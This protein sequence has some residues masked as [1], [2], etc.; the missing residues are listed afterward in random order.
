MHSTV[1][2]PRTI[3]AGVAVDTEALDG[4]RR[5]LA[6]LRKWKYCNEDDAALVVDLLASQ[7]VAASVVNMNRQTQA[8]LKF[9]QDAEVLHEAIV[10][11]SRKPAGWAKPANLLKFLLLSLAC[12]SATGHAIRIHSGPRMLG[13]AGLRLFECATV[14]D[15]EIDGDE[16]REVFE[17][18]WDKQ[19]I[20]QSRLA[21]LGV[22]VISTEVRVT[23]E[24]LEPALLLA[25][26]VAGLGLA[27]AT[28]DPGR[29]PLPLSQDQAN[30]LLFK[31]R[32]AGKLVVVE[33]DFSYSYDEI[34][35]EVMAQARER[36][37]A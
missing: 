18:F 31:L 13:P 30:R 15:S 24:Q 26:Y 9:L 7:G 23:T 5:E 3:S 8:W 21:A 19:H 17:S 25:D 37:D 28:N 1:G 27:A 16:N 32:G 34:F 33:E 22:E 14:C 20:P 4:I 12:A 2:S 35:G 6:Q 11:T 10:S 36:A 29:L